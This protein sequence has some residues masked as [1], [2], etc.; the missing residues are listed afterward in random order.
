MK[1]KID[2]KKPQPKQSKQVRSVPTKETRKQEEALSQVF[3]PQGNT[4]SFT[5]FVPDGHDIRIKVVPSKEFF[6]TKVT[7]EILSDFNLDEKSI[8]KRHTRINVENEY[9]NRIANLALKLP[10]TIL[11]GLAKEYMRLRNLKGTVKI[12]KGRIYICLYKGWTLNPGL[13]HILAMICA[14]P[15]KEYIKENF[16]DKLKE[17]SMTYYKKVANTSKIEATTR[18]G[19]YEY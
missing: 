1:K 7:E 15:S 17:N 9:A 11:N 2:S 19:L 8:L 12:V 6:K 16:K 10:D 13:D 18:K 4:P 5:V 3:D 14:T